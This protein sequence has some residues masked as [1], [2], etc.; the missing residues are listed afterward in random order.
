[1]TKESTYREVKQRRA[2]EQDEKLEAYRQEKLQLQRDRRD[3]ERKA[4]ILKAA[5]Q[6]KQLDPT[7]TLRD[8]MWAATEAYNR[9]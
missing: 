6:L 2:Q 7:L 5:V 8:A 4:E 1:M 9:S 3:A